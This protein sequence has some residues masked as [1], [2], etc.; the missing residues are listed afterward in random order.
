MY[1]HKFE[2]IANSV[3]QYAKVPLKEKDDTVVSELHLT[4]CSKISFIILP[5]W[6][7][8]QGSFPLTRVEK[9]E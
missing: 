8:V 9:A 1:L 7:K 3:S 4:L 2:N 6:L 5:P